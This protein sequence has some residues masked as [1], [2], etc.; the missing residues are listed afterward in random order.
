MCRTSLLY[1]SLHISSH[2]KC[3]RRVF[4]VVIV[5][6]SYGFLLA[7]QMFVFS[8]LTLLVSPE[9]TTFEVMGATAIQNLGIKAGK[10]SA[11]RKWENAQNILGKS[12]PLSPLLKCPLCLW[13]RHHVHYRVCKEIPFSKLPKVL[14]NKTTL[15]P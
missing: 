11:N 13:V 5:L 3:T 14:V 8:D 12:N 10:V 15:V 7:C 1:Q 9:C 4:S 6:E 2:I